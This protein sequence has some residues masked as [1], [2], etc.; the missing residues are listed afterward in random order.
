LQAATVH[1]R[2]IAILQQECETANR[3]ND[4]IEDSGLAWLNSPAFT[5]YNRLLDLE[6]TIPGII[7]FAKAGPKRRLVVENLLEANTPVVMVTAPAGFG[8][9]S[10]CKWHALRDADRLLDHEAGALPVYIPLHRFRLHAPENFETTFFP[11]Q[12]I[13]ELIRNPET[14]VRLYLDGLD[15]IPNEERRAQIVDLA[16]RAVQ[17]Y[18]GIRV[19][20]TSREHVAGPFLD[21]IP[22]LRVQELDDQQQH[23]LVRKWLQTEEHT[24]AFFLHLKALPSL[25]SLLAV[26]LFATLIAAVYKKQRALTSK[27]HCSLQPL[28]GPPMRRLG[29][30]ERNQP[31]Q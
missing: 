10:F 17:V 4:W 15:E 14:T 1:R 5:S 7:S 9:T 25:R 19:L 11:S 3:P 29:L 30:R 28:C 8:K 23:E 22:R 24:E 13:K 31:R 18:P 21:G 26:P 27:P 2:L 6:R 12:E 20:I 16:R